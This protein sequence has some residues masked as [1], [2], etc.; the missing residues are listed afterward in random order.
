MPVRCNYCQRANLPPF[1]LSKGGSGELA[2]PVAHVQPN[3]EPCFQGVSKRD[4]AGWVEN[5]TL[6]GI[7]RDTKYEIGESTWELDEQ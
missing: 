5:G 2:H 3:G 6:S 7:L 4:L 1:P